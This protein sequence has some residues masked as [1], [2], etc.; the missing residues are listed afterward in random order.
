V[1]L[2][3]KGGRLVDP[4]QALH[5]EAD[6]LIEDGVVRRIIGP[7]ESSAAEETEVESVDA[8]GLTV[9]PGVIDMHVHLREPG[10]EYKET[11]ETG[12]AAAAAGGV[13]TVACMANTDPVND[14][15]AVTRFINERAAEAGYV[16]VKPIGAITRGLKGES[17]AEIGELKEAGAVA[18]SDD[19]RSVEQA[20]VLRRAME[21]ARTFGLPIISHCEER[22]LA[23]RGAMN[24]GR[25]SLELG[26]R[27]I[28]AAAEEIIVA[29]DILLAEWTQCPLHIAHASTAGTVRLIR[30]AKSRGVPV[31]AEVTP[32]HL[33]L[34]EEA[35]RQWDTSTKV[36]PPLRTQAD[37][38]ALQEGLADGTIDVIASDHAPHA[39]V[40]KELE[41]EAA[42]SG[43]SGVETLVGLSFMLVHSGRLTL[44]EWVR[45]VSVNPARILSVPGGSLAPGQAADLTLLDLERTWQVEPRHLRSKGKNTPF[46]GWSIRGQAVMTIVG[47]RIVY[48]GL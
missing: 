5:T 28:P 30:A 27:G 10:Y 14:H 48:S 47:G 8:A 11:I 18:L 1:K 43:I 29:R 16:R 40:D 4:A 6:L 37:V 35:V 31:T 23:G 13:T 26:L 3:I 12:T 19:G 41:Y 45:K 2:L 42:A 46:K 44:E 25:L 36:N 24:E 9:I 39:T 32:H 38:E 21:Y 22:T 33:L 17:L 34:T 7:E 20:V 15:G